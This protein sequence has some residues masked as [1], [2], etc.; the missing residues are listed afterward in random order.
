MSKSSCTRFLTQNL[1]AIALLCVT[2]LAIA[3]GFRVIETDQL[4]IAIW[5]PSNA[6]EE[7]HRLGPFDVTYS[8]DS[9]IREGYFQP[10]LMSHGNGGRSRNHHL[11]ARV[12]ADAGYIVIAVQHSADHLIGGS[13]TAGAMALRVDELRQA[14]NAVEMDSV[15]GN[16]L[17]LKRVHALGYSLGGATVMAAA[18]SEINLDAAESHCDAYGIEDAVF[19]EPPPFLWRIYQKLRNPVSIKDMPN[20]FHVEPF[21]N[22]L[23]AVVAPI[24]QGLKITPDR[25]HAFQV[26]VIEIEGDKIAQP[27][28]HAQAIVDMLPPE[29]LVNLVSVPGHHYA[30]IAPFSKRVTA[31][32]DIPVAKDPKGFN[33]KAFIEHVN[34]LIV[35]FFNQ[36]SSELSLLQN[37]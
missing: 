22:G 26:L 13:D 34:T 24:G 9:P 21:V 29:K 1:C 31:K 36:G 16:N 23:V 32:D 7:K 28:F 25:F 15:V 14:L 37:D 30:F 5:Y 10:V 3:V 33:R 11:T 6:P 19:C 18:G 20:H 4:A 27:R 17:D 12:L 2:N 35:D 8:L